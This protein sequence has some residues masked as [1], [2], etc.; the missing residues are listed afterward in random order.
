[1]YSWGGIV[2]VGRPTAKPSCLC[3]KPAEFKCDSVSGRRG[4]KPAGYP[5]KE[6]ENSAVLLIAYRHP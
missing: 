3:L 1:M 2:K 6:R 5:R 4:F